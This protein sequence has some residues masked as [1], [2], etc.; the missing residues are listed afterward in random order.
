MLTTVRGGERRFVGKDKVTWASLSPSPYMLRLEKDD[1]LVVEPS[2]D[3]YVIPLDIAVPVHSQNRNYSGINYGISAHLLGTQ[4]DLPVHDDNLA[5]C[6]GVFFSPLVPL[7]VWRKDP[8]TPPA[9]QLQ[10]WNLEPT[11]KYVA[12]GAAFVNADRWPIVNGNMLGPNALTTLH[13]GD[14]VQFPMMLTGVPL[15]S[16]CFLTYVVEPRPVDPNQMWTLNIRD[17][18][19][20]IPIQFDSTEYDLYGVKFTARV[21]MLDSTEHT[22]KNVPSVFILHSKLEALTGVSMYQLMLWVSNSS[23]DTP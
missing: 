10:S 5:H 13:F 9:L 17:P 8:Q 15:N 18:M 22:L 6:F 4:A 23:C 1:R 20:R 3:T 2:G 21:T 14:R 12:D 11:G 7:E 19:P 16:P